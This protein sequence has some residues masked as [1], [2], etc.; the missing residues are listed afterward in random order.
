MAKLNLPK[1]KF[2][3]P[4]NVRTSTK[5][6]KKRQASLWRW[7]RKDKLFL[8]LVLIP[9]LL[10]TVYFVIFAKDRYVSDSL[11]LVKRADD[12]GGMDLTL[13]MLV[14]GGNA[15]VKEDA[16]L[17]E[18]YILSPDMFKKLDEKLNF[19]EAFKKSGADLFQRYPQDTIFEENFAYYL[20]KISVLFDEKTGVLTIA[21]Q[22]FTPTFARQFNRVLLQESEA[23]LNELSNTITRNQ[24]TE[25]QDAVHRTYAELQNAETSLLQFQN[26]NKL[27]D[28][29]IQIESTSR[30]IAELE[31]K[32]A[33]LETDKNN[34]STYLN[35]NTPQIRAAQ[36]AIN[37][38]NAQ[39]RKEQ[40][41]L[42]S[43]DNN[44]LNEKMLQFTEL[45]GKV[46][47]AADLYKLALGALEKSKNE[48]TRKSRILAVVSQPV[49][50]DEAFY[51]R[52][53]YSLATILLISLLVYGLVK[54]VV[55]IIRDHRM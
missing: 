19:Q 13:S 7:V 26:K 50:A 15:T 23:F 54:V 47:F 11:V 29:Q 46:S 38:I 44:R 6:A 1:P 48:V 10:S 25:A 12:S 39:I 3:V 51:P 16:L 27:I 17:L 20:S 18:R 45:K 41:Q 22:G 24:I 9:F 49:M 35:D 14:G 30:L 52:K 42:T 34:L 53:I 33:Q 55:S 36:S 28:P 40:A 8:W 31:A 21:T 43:G 2:N 4:A 32:K 5:W 37:A